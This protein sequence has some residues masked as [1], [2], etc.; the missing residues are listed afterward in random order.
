MDDYALQINYWTLK[1]PLDNDIIVD[2]FP[3]HTIHVIWLLDVVVFGYIKEEFK[4]LLR[5]R[6]ITKSKELSMISLKFVNC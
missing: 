4:K 3:A 2:G 1:L 5:L 6:T